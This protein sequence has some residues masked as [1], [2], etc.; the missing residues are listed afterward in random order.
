MEPTRQPTPV[1]GSSIRGCTGREDGSFVREA[2][3]PF[4]TPFYT[5]FQDEEVARTLLSRERT[6]RDPGPSGGILTRARSLLADRV[7]QALSGAA[8]SAEQVVRLAVPVRPV[9]P[10]RWLRGQS[11]FPRMYWSGREDGF[12]VA[13]IGAADLQESDTPEGVEELR[14]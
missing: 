14:K 8:S 7:S 5:T 12:G 11:Q 4:A 3:R 1:T 13:A 10:F 2:A 9:E 6:A